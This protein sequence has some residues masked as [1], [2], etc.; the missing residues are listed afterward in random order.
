[1]KALPQPGAEE[2]AARSMTKSTVLVNHSSFI[3]NEVRS[4]GDLKTRVNSQSVVCVQ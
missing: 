2:L 1:M 4:E 3:E